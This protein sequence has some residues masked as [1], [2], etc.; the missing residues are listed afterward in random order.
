MKKS[1]KAYDMP[2][3][4]ARQPK[5]KATANKRT[6]SMMKNRLKKNP[7]QKKGS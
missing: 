6:L 2:K 4:K 5:Q 3:A 1:G 7:Y